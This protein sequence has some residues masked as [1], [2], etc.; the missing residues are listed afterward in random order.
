MVFL[1]IIDLCRTP[2]TDST[3]LWGS[4]EPWLR[5]TGLDYWNYT[6]TINRQITTGTFHLILTIWW[7]YT[8]MAWL[9][10]SQRYWHDIYLHIKIIKLPIGLVVTFLNSSLE[11]LLTIG[12]SFKLWHWTCFQTE[13]CKCVCWSMQ[14]FANYMYSQI[15]TGQMLFTLF[16]KNYYFYIVVLEIGWLV[17]L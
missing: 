14:V 6:E 17:D 4:I 12:F 7:Q 16:V 3:N 1:R 13:R 9:I 11:F 10:M 5:T 8:F 2:E 15:N